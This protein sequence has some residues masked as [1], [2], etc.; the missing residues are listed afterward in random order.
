MART[1]SIYGLS[2]KFDFGCNKGKTVEEVITS[3]ENYIHWCIQ[4]VDWFAISEDCF[5]EM[6]LMQLNDIINKNDEFSSQLR[7]E[8][9]VKLEEYNNIVS[10]YNHTD[11]DYYDSYNDD[12]YYDSNDWLVD[13]A[14]SND[15]EVMNDVYWNLD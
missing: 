10:R 5:L 6:Q 4:N 11:N 9:S 1:L 8:N 7:D 12:Y 15:P 3:N 13:A 14:G 2:T